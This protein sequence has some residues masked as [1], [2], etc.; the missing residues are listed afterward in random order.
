MARGPNP[1]PHWLFFSPGTRPCFHCITAAS[2][3]VKRLNFNRKPGFPE[4]SRVLRAFKPS[5]GWACLDPQSGSPTP[6]V[7]RSG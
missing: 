6:P 5:V 3:Q 1:C 7:G 4:Y 2:P